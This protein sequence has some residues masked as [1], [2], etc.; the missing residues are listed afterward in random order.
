MSRP[1]GLTVL[2]A[3]RDGAAFIAEAIASVRASTAQVPHIVM[4]DGSRDATAAILAATDGLERVTLPQSIGP[5]AALNLAFARAKTTHCM[6]VDADDRVTPGH[7]DRLLGIIAADPGLDFIWSGI[8]E[9]AEP[10][11]AARYLVRTEQQVGYLTSGAVVR[12]E[13]FA[14]LGGFDP[15]IRLGYFVDLV[16]R[17]RSMG[18]RE[19]IC[20]ELGLE[21]RVHGANM[22]IRERERKGDFL[23]IAR[24]AV[25]RHRERP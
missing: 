8:R 14:A 24:A 18:V 12:T 6:V 17:A 13:L 20:P 19:H 5:A 25:L 3:V 1:P 4:D 10:A 15:Q 7:I 11:V 16:A 22:T 2:T 23:A 21:R 9:F